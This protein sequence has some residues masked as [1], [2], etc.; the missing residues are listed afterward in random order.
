[1]VEAPPIRDH[2]DTQSIP[3]FLH[4]FR[5]PESGMVIESAQGAAI[6]PV[7]KENPAKVV[8]LV[9]QNSSIP[10]GSFNHVRSAGSVETVNAY[11]P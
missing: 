9:L 4:G 1:L 5:L 6:H 10:S 2:S 11:V 8:D 3:H 7:K